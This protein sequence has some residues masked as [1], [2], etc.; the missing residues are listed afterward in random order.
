LYGGVVTN[1]HIPKNPEAA[2]DEQ[3]KE[4]HDFFKANPTG[5]YSQ[6]LRP[7]QDFEA[8]AA[9]LVGYDNT[10]GREHW[11]LKNSWGPEFADKGFFRVR[12]KPYLQSS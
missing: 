3:L 12:F 4:F 8:H 7:G 11:I 1:I 2:A 6:E 9:F 5:V 10:H